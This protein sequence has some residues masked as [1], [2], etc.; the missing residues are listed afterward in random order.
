LPRK[1]TEEEVEEFSKMVAQGC[2]HGELMKKFNRSSK[3]I[4]GKKIWLKRSKGKPRMKRMH[5][6]FEWVPLA[7]VEVL[8]AAVSTSHTLSLSQIRIKIKNRYP[9]RCDDQHKSLMGHTGWKISITRE[10]S[11]YPCFER[12]EDPEQP[13]RDP[14]YHLVDMEDLKKIEREFVMC[15]KNSRRPNA[16]KSYMKKAMN[17]VKAFRK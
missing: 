11:R 16:R 7:I 10:L 12:V 15:N 14:K 6:R 2:S 4:S 1:W 9:T 5:A 13:K 17:Y 3:S 8:G